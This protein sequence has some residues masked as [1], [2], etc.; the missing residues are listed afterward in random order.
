MEETTQQ[1]MHE[2]L[3]EAQGVSDFDLLPEWEEK[4][5]DEE[6]VHM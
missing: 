5:S 2:T 6:D 1:G 3:E 4:E